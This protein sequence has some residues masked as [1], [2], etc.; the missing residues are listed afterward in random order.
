MQRELLG[1]TKGSKLRTPRLG[2]DLKSLF[3][4]AMFE[5][6]GEGGVCYHSS[7]SL[8]HDLYMCGQT[9]DCNVQLKPQ[10]LNMS[11]MEILSGD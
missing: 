3:T 8:K 11:D 7:P 1:R 9:R 6:G 10:S 5:G 2:D 4:Y